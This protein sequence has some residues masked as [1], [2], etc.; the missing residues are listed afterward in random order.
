MDIISQIAPELNHIIGQLVQWIHSLVPSYG[1]AV[2]LFTVFLKIITLPMDY[3]QRY[4][5]RKNMLLQKKLKPFTD[6]IDRKYAVDPSDSKYQE[7]QRIAASEKQA[8]YKKYGYSLSAGCL[9]MIIM[10]AIFLFYV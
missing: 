9:P 6:Q 1:L 8:L 10:M 5:M 4:S 2:I 3:W 7:N